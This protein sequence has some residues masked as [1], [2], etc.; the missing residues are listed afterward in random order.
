MNSQVW[1]D[2]ITRVIYSIDQ[3]GHQHPCLPPHQQGERRHGYHFHHITVV[4]STTASSSSPLPSPASHQQILECLKF[5]M[6]IVTF[7]FTPI[8]ESFSFDRGV[9]VSPGNLLPC[10]TDF[11]ELNSLLRQSYTLPAC[12]SMWRALI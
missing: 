10:R 1:D 7:S 3:H 6:D 9:T 8:K 2:S 11:Y 12:Y 5:A 4:I